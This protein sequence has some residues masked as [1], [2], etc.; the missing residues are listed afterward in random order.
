MTARRIAAV[1]ALMLT[2]AAPARAEEPVTD[3][4]R[5]AV[6]TVIAGQI[7]A[8]KHDDAAAAYGFASPH[9]QS[10]FGSPDTFIGMVRRAYKPVY[11]PQSI[12][13]GALAWEDGKLVQTVNVIGP[14][15]RSAVARYTMEREPDGTWRIDAC[16]LALGNYLGT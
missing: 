15:G 14:D 3:T 9:I 2:V 12:E 8:F 4:L 6:K 11:R 1:L 13:F 16:E 5:G 10:L 7:E